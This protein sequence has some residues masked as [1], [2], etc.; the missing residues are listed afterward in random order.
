MEVAECGLLENVLERVREGRGASNIREKGKR[1][2]MINT[3]AEK[4][5]T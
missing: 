3:Q 2:F 4:L 1:E 5:D